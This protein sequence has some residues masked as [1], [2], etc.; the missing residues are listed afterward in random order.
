[1][2]LIVHIPDEIVP[3][4]QAAGGDLS[5]QALEALALE[6]YRNDRITKKQLRKM[7]G[8]ETRYELDGFFKDHNF[9]DGLSAEEI[10]EQVETAKQLGF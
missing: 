6:A 1:M 8:F 5:R 9:Y 7:L 4:L 3:Q 2:D 10:M